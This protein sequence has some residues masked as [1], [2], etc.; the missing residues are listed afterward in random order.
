MWPGLRR[1]HD[2]DES[3]VGNVAR[4]EARARFWGGMVRILCKKR[5]FRWLLESL[6]WEMWPGLW[7]E[8]DSDESDVGSESRTEA[9]DES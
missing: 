9:R 5:W 4:T 6:M 3:D 8:H 7:R 1:E 2:S